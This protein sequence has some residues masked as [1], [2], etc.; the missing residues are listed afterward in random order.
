MIKWG[1][2]GAGN[3]A[4]RFATS[5]ASFENAQLVAVANRTMAKAQSFQERHHAQMAFDNYQ[6]LLDL[7]EIDMVYIALPH[8]Y[9]AEW[10]KKSILAG[11]GILCEKPIVIHADELIAIQQLLAKQPVFFME[12]MKNR[13]TPA[14]QKMAQLV[15]GGAIGTIQEI[16]TCLRRDMPKEGTTYHYL[17]EQGGCLL[18][19]GIY[20][21]ALLTDFVHGTP[22]IDSLN[23]TFADS[24]EISVEAT[25][26]CNQI[27]LII[28]SG[29][30][31]FKPAL[32]TIK[33]T[34]GIIT[35]PDFHRPTSFHIDYLDGQSQ[36][37]SLPYIQD[38]FHGEVAHAMNCFRQGL[39]ESPQMSWSD[40]LRCAQWIDW[41]KATGK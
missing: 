2:I 9:H 18:D 22:T 20:N 1:I 8:A 34:K 37:Y 35:I 33:G 24:I 6:E 15:K 5:L 21:I 4:H 13:F 31:L 38:D 30:D 3:I 11:K 7:E 10:I 36:S 25:L 39:Y 17:P 26:T 16:E 19:M 14:Y 28:E 32:A 12:A 29:F 40:S 23:A 41:L 27:P